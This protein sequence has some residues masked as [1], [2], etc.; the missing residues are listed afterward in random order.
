MANNKGKVPGVDRDHMMFTSR[1]TDKEFLCSCLG[2]VYR[3]NSIESMNPL[4][5]DLQ[6]DAL[7]NLRF[8]PVYFGPL[9]SI[10]LNWKMIQHFLPSNYAERT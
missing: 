8:S 5:E 7:R 9:V 1:K 4:L 6:D 2:G 10:Y 3:R